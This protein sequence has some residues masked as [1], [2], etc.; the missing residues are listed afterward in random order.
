MRAFDRLGVSTPSSTLPSSPARRDPRRC[1]RVGAHRARLRG[2]LPHRY[3][4]PYVVAH[5]HD[6]LDAL[7]EPAG[8]SRASRWGPTARRSMCVKPPKQPRSPS[9]TARST[10]PD[11]LVGAD[12]IRSQRAAPA[13]RQR[14]HLQRSRRLPRRDLPW[15]TCP[16]TY[17]AGSPWTRCYC[18]SA[19]A[20]T[21]CSTRCA[22]ANDVQPGRR[23]RAAGRTPRGGGRR[24]RVR[25]GVRRACEQVRASVALVDTARG[26]G[27]YT[28]EIRSRHGATAHAVAASAMRPT[29]CSSTS[30]KAPARR[31]RTAWS[32]ARLSNASAQQ[33]PM[34]FN[35]YEQVRRPIASRCQT[36]ARPWGDLWHTEDP[37]LLAAAQSRVPDSAGP[38][39]TP[40]WT[41]STANA[42]Q[43]CSTA[44]PG[45]P[46]RP[47]EQRVNPASVTRRHTPIG[48]IQPEPKEQDEVPQLPHP[49]RP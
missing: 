33:C 18:G 10:A 44:R 37:T 3:G 43:R 14:P 31:S 46:R 12:G 20:S 34:A 40:T 7:L 35:A 11:L 27:R 30:V 29:R 16:P 47:P 21:S 2:N 48:T 42:T 23:L 32:S 26:T 6:V 17:L 22:A 8:P 49:H 38:T 41:G 15:T 4:Y 19:P 9:P 24:R 13:R 28:T 45:P 39:T 1:R 25:R 36:V 5:R